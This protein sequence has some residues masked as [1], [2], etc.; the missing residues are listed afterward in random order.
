LGLLDLV[1]ARANDAVYDAAAAQ[2]SDEDLANLIW[3]IAVINAWN[4]LGATARP[5]PLAPSGA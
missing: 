1:R 5:W 3:L 4:R 2:F